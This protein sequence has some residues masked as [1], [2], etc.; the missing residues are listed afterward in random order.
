MYLPMFVE[1]IRRIQQGKKTTT[2]RPLKCNYKIGEHLTLEGTYLRV[3]ITDRRQITVPG[4]LTPK[5]ARGEGYKN[6]QEMID[7]MY[8]RYRGNLPP[9][10]WLY[11]FALAAPK[12]PR[13]KSSF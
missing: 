1:S 12:T 10:W 2:L 4:D 8:A 11:T 7:A 6:V 5:I 13:S 9:Q 3:Q